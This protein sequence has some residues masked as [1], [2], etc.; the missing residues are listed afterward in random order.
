MTR[1]VEK[2]LRGCGWRSWHEVDKQIVFRFVLA[3]RVTIMQ[4][5]LFVERGYVL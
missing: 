4:P 3:K 1:E 5:L 2:G